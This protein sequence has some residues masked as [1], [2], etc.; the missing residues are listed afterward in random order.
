MQ[1]CT[2]GHSGD[3]LV[4]V[5]EVAVLELGAAAAACRRVGWRPVG[6][7]F[8]NVHE[9][10]LRQHVQAFTPVP[11]EN[12]IGQNFEIRDGSAVSESRAM[13]RPASTWSLHVQQHGPRT[14]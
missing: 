12:L 9:T 11:T 14:R 10:D 13:D 7:G 8:A 1:R 6:H 4:D 2:A 3:L 5:H